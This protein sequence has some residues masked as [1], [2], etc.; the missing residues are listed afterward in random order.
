M[1]SASSAATGGGVA[2]TT[3]AP[4]A[5]FVRH[6]PAGAIRLTAPTIRTPATTR[7]RSWPSGGISSCATAPVSR[8]QSR[9]LRSAS[10][11]CSSSRSRHRQTSSPQLPKR[12][13]TTAG[14]S[15]SGSGAFRSIS[16][17]RGCGR[18]ARRSSRAV[19]SLSWAS[20]TAAGWLSTRTPAS[21]RRSSAPRPSS[22]PSSECRTSSR[23]SATSPRP[24]ASSASPGVSSSPRTPSQPHAARAR[25]VGLALC[26]TTAKRIHSELCAVVLGAWAAI[27]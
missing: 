10:A 4:S 7:R 20:T 17:V 23:A 18:P 3:L 22:T 27:W 11:A 16:V 12:G 15:R 25:F 24:S 8:N 9:P 26:A 19:R 2:G 21:A 13:L 1:A 5:T 14:K 6:S